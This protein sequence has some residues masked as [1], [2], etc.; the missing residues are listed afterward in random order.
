MKTINSVSIWDNG[1]VHEAKI[2]NAYAT[3][4]TLGASATFFFQ[5]FSQSAE[6]HIGQQVTQ[7]TLN[8]TGEDYQAWSQDDFAWDWVATKLNLTITGDYVA[9]APPVVEPVAP[10]EPEVPTEPAVGGE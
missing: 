7:G 8:M 10:I 2:L 4:L 1:T 5:L 6:G 3:N 9:P